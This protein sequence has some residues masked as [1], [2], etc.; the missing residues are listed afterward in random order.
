M[1]RLPKILT[2]RWTIRLSLPIWQRVAREPKP[3]RLVLR[4]A[5]VVRS[6]GVKRVLAELVQVLSEARS[7][8]G[9]VL[10]LRPSHVIL[11]KRSTA[12]CIVRR[13]APFFLSLFGRSAWLLWTIWLLIVPRPRHLLPS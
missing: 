8:V 10:H 1:L 4:L 11:S 13:C 6:P 12:R 9:A 3:R 5:A 2:R 7:G